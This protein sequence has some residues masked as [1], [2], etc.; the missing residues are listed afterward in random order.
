MLTRCMRCLQGT[1]QHYERVQKWTKRVDIFLMDY[2]FVPIHADTHW[3]LA[4]VCHPGACILLSGTCGVSILLP[5]SVHRC[6][7]GVCV[8]SCR[9]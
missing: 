4:V 2:L 8:A 7:A 9:W 6:H 3:S 1:L 5:D